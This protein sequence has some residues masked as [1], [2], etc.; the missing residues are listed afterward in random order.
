MGERLKNYT[1]PFRR[2]APSVLFGVLTLCVWVLGW[3]GD[4]ISLYNYAFSQPGRII[5]RSHSLGIFVVIWNYRRFLDNTCLLF[6][7]IVYRFVAFIELIH[8]LDYKG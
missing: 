5:Q 2:Y 1:N 7:G 3:G 6:S 4:V 8:N